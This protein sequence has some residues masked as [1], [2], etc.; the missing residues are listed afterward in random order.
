MAATS[1]HWS[2]RLSRTWRTRK[3]ILFGSW[4]RSQEWGLSRNP[5]VSKVSFPHTVRLGKETTLTLMLVVPKSMPMLFTVH[6][7]FFDFHYTGRGKGL[8]R[9]AKKA[10]S[11]RWRPFL[12][13]MCFQ[14][15]GRINTCRP[16]R[17]QPQGQ[18]ERAL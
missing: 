18:R 14:P 4:A 16:S 15:L 6:A 8:S 17:R 11:L 1:G 9:R 3:R 7:P 12:R 2:R 10:P 13:S 5:P